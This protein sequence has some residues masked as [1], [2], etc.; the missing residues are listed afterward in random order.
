[1]QPDGKL[2]GSSNKL[3]KHIV[4]VVDVYKDCMTLR[5]LDK[6]KFAKGLWLSRSDTLT[7]FTRVR[8]RPNVKR[9]M[10]RTKLS[11]LRS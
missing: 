7:S 4:V 2:S 3:G 1:M 5:C 11:E 10:R 9:F 6:S 8:P